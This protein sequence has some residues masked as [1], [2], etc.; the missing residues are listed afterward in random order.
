MTQR[1]LG[2]LYLLKIFS[3]SAITS[4]GK[5]RLVVTK[6]SMSSFSCS[7]E[8]APTI[9]LVINGRSLTNPNAS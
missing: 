1:K 6:A 4:A 2:S 3:T 7:R 8:V 9:E 5:G